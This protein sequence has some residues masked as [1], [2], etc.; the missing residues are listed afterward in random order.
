MKKLLPLLYL[1]SLCAPFTGLA[2]VYDVAIIGSGP[3][4][5]SAAYVTGSHERSTVLIGGPLEGGPINEQ[6]PVANWPGVKQ[7]SGDKIMK[8]LFK[9]LPK[10][11]VTHIEGSVA[12]LKTENRPFEL[13]LTDGTVIEAKAVILATGTRPR[14]LP[15]ENEAEMAERFVEYE[16]LNRNDYEK[17]KGMEQVLVVGS[18]EDA[19]RKAV[20]GA[21]NAQQVTL[22]VRGEK[23]KGLPWK[24]RSVGKAK[25]L[26]LYF[27]SQITSAKP[28]KAGTKLLVEIESKDPDA[29]ATMEVD[30]ILSAIGRIPNGEWIP[31]A[32][33]KTPGGFVVLAGRSQATNIPGIFAAGGVADALRYG[34]AG[35][36]TGEG[37][38]AG[39]DALA[40][41][42][43]SEDLK[44]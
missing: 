35:I 20:L 7:T 15:L 37:M 33:E 26:E 21:R 43:K 1:V 36:A 28:N 40:Y 2:K 19:M 8:R 31:E 30:K 11:Y 23:L 32:I 9:D 10:E 24:Q 6:T 16:I 34:Q 29:P 22:L 39:Y 25:N 4:G 18:G 14:R 3:A 42:E 5:L 17:L 41:L 13:E 44:K 12:D 38:K 27:S